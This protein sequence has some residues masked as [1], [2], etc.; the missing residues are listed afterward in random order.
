MKKLIILMTFGFLLLTGCSKEET[1]DQIPEQTT[2]MV[3]VLKQSNGTVA[4][5]AMEVNLLKNNSSGDENTN[6]SNSAHAHGNY[7]AYGGSTTITFSGTEN[8]GGT[9]GSAEFRQVA[10]PYEVHL[11]METASVAVN[12]NEAIYGGIITEVITDTFPTLPP[13]PPPPPCPTF[14]NCPPPPPPPSCSPNSVGSYIYFKVFDNGQGSNAPTDQYQGIVGTC[15]RS[16]NGAVNFP[17]FIF[18]E[19]QDVENSSDKIKVN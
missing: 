7:T 18:G 8:N 11:I 6:R 10:G 4:W 15:N 12:G 2:D 14:P 9:H 19:P 13:P 5:E 17:W 16:A 1:T 3:Y